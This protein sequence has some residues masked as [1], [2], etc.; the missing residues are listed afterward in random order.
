MH[1]ANKWENIEKIRSNKST[2]LKNLKNYNVWICWRSSGTKLHLPCEQRCVSVMSTTGLLCSFP[3]PLYW[4]PAPPV[5][6]WCR[7]EYVVLPF[8]FLGSLGSVNSRLF[9]V[10]HSA[11]LRSIKYKQEG[12]WAH[13]PRGLRFNTWFEVW[14][15]IL[16]CLWCSI[17]YLIREYTGPV[18]LTAAIVVNLDLKSTKSFVSVWRPTGGA[19]MTSFVLVLSANW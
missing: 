1:F 4:W 13:N 11:R 9:S 15:P 16:P 6:R 14:H 7:Q 8:K 12:G 5:L 17:L 18:S 3:G 10:H 2:S 19:E